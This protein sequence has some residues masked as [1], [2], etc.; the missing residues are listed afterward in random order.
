MAGMSETEELVSVF[1]KCIKPFTTQPVDKL[2][3]DDFFWI[4]SGEVGVNNDTSLL[5]AAWFTPA[6]WMFSILAEEFLLQRAR[7]G[8]KICDR[9]VQKELSKLLEFRLQSQ[10]ESLVYGLDVAVIDALGAEKYES[11]AAEGLG[12]ALI[13]YPLSVQDLKAMEWEGDAVFFAENMWLEFDF[14]WIHALR[15]QLNMAS[16]GSSLAV[17]YWE[18]EGDLYSVGLLP[19]AQVR[20]LFPYICFTG[21]MEWTFFLPPPV[22]EADPA[23]L[24]YRRGCLQLPVLDLSHSI[25]LECIKRSLPGATEQQEQT[26]LE[27]LRL[28]KGQKHGALLIVADKEIVQKEIERLCQINNRGIQFTKAIPLTGKSGQALLQFSS[29][30]G[31]LFVDLEGKCHAC[32]VILDGAACVAGDMARGARLNSAKNYIDIVRRNFQG[33]A[34]ALVVSEDGMAS[35]L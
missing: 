23:R 10:L 28:A 27:L 4:K 19:Q 25:E 11:Q 34:A 6:K 15:K 14:D 20:A 3:G 24:V 7:W 32:A 33:R 1:K 30:D 17:C 29:I 26:V 8:D 2:I 22:G 16:K 9:S 18:E 35:I 21:H 5:K 31:A 12:L 13:P